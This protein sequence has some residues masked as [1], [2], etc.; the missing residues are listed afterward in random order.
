MEGAS[1]SFLAY[2]APA[3]V[4]FEYRQSDGVFI[5]VGDI[6]V[7]PNPFNPKAALGGVLKF[8]NVPRGAIIGIYTLSGELTAAFQAKTAYVLWDGTNRLNNPVSPGIYYYHIKWDENRKHLRGKI[9]VTG[10]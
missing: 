7:Y 1:V 3:P 9:F 5:S 8:A 10:E 4:S 6:R 2:P